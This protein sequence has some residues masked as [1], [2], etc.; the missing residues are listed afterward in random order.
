MPAS[1]GGILV[2]LFDSLTV[3]RRL[4]EAGTNRDQADALA[5]AIRQAAEHGD[6]VTSETLRTELATL[7]ADL[8]RA[9]LLQTVAIIGAGIA[10]LRLG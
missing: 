4:T 10:V 6:H 5:D 1:A 8:Y 9:M 7:R 2:R 3:T